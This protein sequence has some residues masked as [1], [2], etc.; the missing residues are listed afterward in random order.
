M[1]HNKKIKYLCKYRAIL[2][3]TI[4]KDTPEREAVYCTKFRK[5]VS[6]LFCS[7]ECQYNRRP[8]GSNSDSRYIKTTGYIGPEK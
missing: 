3:V 2:K 1:V 5:D 7:Y 8:T 4:F 6:D